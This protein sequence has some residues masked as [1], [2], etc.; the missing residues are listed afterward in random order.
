M[1]SIDEFITNTTNSVEK[2]A[3]VKTK[4]WLK[5]K[6]VNESGLTPEEVHEI[7]Y[8]GIRYDVSLEAEEVLD[9]R[10]S[11]PDKLAISHYRVKFAFYIRQV[12]RNKL[13]L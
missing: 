5:K 9:A 12:T 7:R 4:K 13:F 2:S 6:T 11:E 3:S 8:A 10:M 1:T